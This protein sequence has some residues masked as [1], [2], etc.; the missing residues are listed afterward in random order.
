VQSAKRDITIFDFSQFDIL[1]NKIAV[2]LAVTKTI[3]EGSAGDIL[4][5][6]LDGSPFQLLIIAPSGYG[7]STVVRH[8]INGLT[9]DDLIIL[10]SECEIGGEYDSMP[11]S[12]KMTQ[13]DVDRF[14]AFKIRDG[15]RKLIV[16]D[17]V[18]GMGIRGWRPAQYLEGLSANARHYGISII[19]SLQVV[20]AAPNGMIENASAALIAVINDRTKKIHEYITG[21]KL[22]SLELE[23]H[24][25]LFIT[26]KGVKC[27]I[28]MES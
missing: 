23:Y 21:M 11:E 25:F 14:N 9:Y 7:K 13:F 26:K 10:S 18:M 28:K 20:K 22:T 4:I 27:K 5:D 2:E 6:N 1:M 19:S 12:V 8:L 17:D 15:R 16:L 3:R 24:S